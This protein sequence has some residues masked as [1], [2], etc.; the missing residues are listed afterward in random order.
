[1]FIETKMHPPHLRGATVERPRLIAMLEEAT[2][3]RLAIVSSPAGFGKSTLLAQWAVKAAVGR[4]IA[5]LSVDAQDNDLARFL[6]YITGTLNRA[7]ATIAAHAL[8][9]IE[10]SP[11][12]P[13]ESILAGLVND[14]SRLS[15]PVYLV[16]D[17]AHLIISSE[18]A[19]F[20]N[21]LVTYAPPALHVVLATRGELPVDAMRM[22]GQVV[23][24][25][26]SELRF[27]LDETD[28][29]LRQVCRLDLST[30][31]VV[32]LHHKTEGW[33]LGLQLVS[34]TLAHEP[35]KEKFITEFSGSQ[36]DVAGFLAHEV[37]ARQPA[38]V[39][40]LLLRT[41]I[42]ERFNLGLV[43]AVSPDLDG[44]M[45]LA[46]IER[47]NLFLIALD[48][49]GHWFRYHHLFSDFLRGKLAAWSI[50]RRADLHRRASAWLSAN[51]YVS[52]AV[53]HALAAG[54]QDV[55]A[56]LVEKCA[57]P[58]IMQ[59][60]IPLVTEWLNRLP[61]DVIATRPRLLLTRVWAH[62]HTGRSREAVRVLKQAKQLV[63]KLAR[64]GAIDR[65]T[66]RA[67]EAELRTLTTGVVSAADWPRM[68]TKLAARWLADYP[69]GE[70]FAQGTLSNIR[71]F[72]HFSLGESDA[73]RLAALKARDHHAAAHSIFGIVYADLILGLVE[74][75][76]GNLPQ[77]HD[78]LTRAR[79]LAR[80]RLGANSYSE[81]MSAIIQVELLYEWDDLH[82]AERL[83]HQ[84]RR[85]IEEC[86]LVVHEMACKLHLARLAQANGRHD[87]AI[88]HLERAEQLGMEKR[89]RRLTVSALNDRVRLLLSRGDVAAARMA[90]QLRG[91]SLTASERA[92]DIHPLEEHAHIGVARVLIAEGHPKRAIAILE[93][94]AER[95]R[96]DG[97][98]RGL[99]QVRA[100][101]AIAAHAAGET[102]QAL[103]ATVDLITLAL[104][105][106][107]MRSLVDEGPLLKAALDFARGRI[108]AWSRKSETADFVER[109]MAALNRAGAGR[110]PMRISG[111][112]SRKP[113]SGKEMEVASYL[114]CAYSNR[115]LAQSLAMAP[116]T[117]KWHLKNIF[118]KLGVSNRTEA[119]LKLKEIGLIAPP[120][121]VG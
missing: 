100:L 91:I 42:L 43:Q 101:V 109:V 98:L 82:S 71:A 57:T 92:K 81:A 90:L 22:K 113:L 28:H 33:P 118:G 97:R 10:S 26:A 16:L 54:D 80:E 120:E 117:V 6:R 86:G 7:D 61:P 13:V 70:P 50:A 62:F 96:R 94:I 49:T 103:A 21:A 44:A 112:S 4:R 72:A 51:G 39:Q 119:V 56:D 14:L 93:R 29:Y 88:F 114:M 66:I 18:I 85:V 77:A 74:L 89:Y 69:E 68:A 40:D 106:R 60:H 116:D 99:I 121:S 53:G 67:L 108:P 63:A 59:G 19:V 38:E 115:Q 20:L 1:M 25:G 48:S 75:S 45:I 76:A 12:T 11:V 102:L 32:A 24:L 41:S 78:L 8:S 105:Q 84:H 104:P 34:L 111:Q 35:S 17:D 64:D 107:A 3:G 2:Q 15:E 65:K 95:Q 30:A 58:I 9:L 23:N 27:S 110:A 83:L 55:A 5:W 73:A 46:L 31:G 52:D 79:Q 87:E 47:A 37:L 36:R